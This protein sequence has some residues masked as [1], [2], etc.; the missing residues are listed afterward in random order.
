[1]LYN[2][3]LPPPQPVRHIVEPLK[4][5]IF[6]HQLRPKESHVQELNLKV[7]LISTLKLQLQEL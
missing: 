4:K 5:H 2:R 6:S 3:K 7:Q 1:M